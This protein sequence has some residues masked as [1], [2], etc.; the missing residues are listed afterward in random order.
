MEYLLQI[1]G[2]IASIGSIPLAVYLYLKSREAK[3]SNVRREIAK[4]LS[5]QIGEG[6]EL[7]TFEVQAV[8]DSK[9]R[10]HK[11]KSKSIAVDEIVED[12][13]SETI[14]SPM[15][16]GHQKA[17]IVDNLRRVYS[18]GM[19]LNAIDRY[20]LSY[21][22]FLKAVEPDVELTR[23]EIATQELAIPDEID[24]SKRGQGFA[25]VFG[26]VVTLVSVIT[27]VLSLVATVGT[28][29]IQRYF[30][31]EIVFNVLL[32][33]AGSLLAGIITHLLFRR[34]TRSSVTRVRQKP[35]QRQNR[36]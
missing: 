24:S 30:G 13:V 33:L 25:D 11:L 16:N 15:L 5:F 31:R 4:I 22:N 3:Y 21:Q 1:L 2:S 32:G 10:E 36:D 19:I 8:I 14:S 20:H 12:L 34:S 18:K 27:A 7:T 26:F 23:R 17:E 6:R 28:G 35:K 29:W 9:I